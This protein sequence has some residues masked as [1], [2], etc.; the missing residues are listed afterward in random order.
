MH[1]SLR[2]VAALASVIAGLSLSARTETKNWTI[3]DGVLHDTKGEPVGM[4][5]V[6]LFQTHMVWASRKIDDAE[7]KKQI[8][9][10]AAENFNVIRM[11]LTW[12]YIEP[13]PDLFPDDPRYQDLMEE[14]GLFTGYVQ[15]LDTILDR[16]AE[17]GIKVIPE[18]HYA[19]ITSGGTWDK[20]K[21]DWGDDYGPIIAEHTPKALGWLANHWK[22]HPAIL[23]FEVPFNEPHDDPGEINPLF[24][25][26]TYYAFVQACARAIKTHAP[27]HLVF[28]AP[29]EWGSGSMRD[30]YTWR[31]PPEIDALFPHAYIGLH[32]PHP[33]PALEHA[34]SAGMA[35]YIAPFRASDRP[36]FVG[37]WGDCMVHELDPDTEKRSARSIDACLA[38]WF[39]MGLQG[40]TWWAW[41]NGVS[42]DLD[43]YR[44]AQKNV[45]PD[46]RAALRKWLWFQEAG[47][48]LS[49]A[50]VAVV[51]SKT[52]G[53]SE[54]DLE[55]KTGTHRL[56]W[57]LDIT[58]R[59]NSAYT[60]LNEH[61][62]ATPG[63]YTRRPWDFELKLAPAE[64]ART[65]R[66]A[67]TGTSSKH[68]DFKQGEE[69]S[70]LESPSG[71]A[72]DAKATTQGAR[73][74][75]TVDQAAGDPLDLKGTLDFLTDGEH[76]LIVQADDESELRLLSGR[77]HDATVSHDGFMK[78]L[79]G[80]TES[81]LELNVH[82][83]D[84]VTLEQLEA[85]PGVLSE[86]KAVLLDTRNLPHPPELSLPVFRFDASIDRAA[87]RKFLE[88]HG[89]QTR[90]PSPLLIA[91]NSVGVMVYNRGPDPVADSL[92]LSL[93]E[94]VRGLTRFHH[95]PEA[96]TEAVPSG[97]AL[98]V[99]L[100]P[101]QAEIFRYLR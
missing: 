21:I 64:K 70:F 50:Q 72:E 95:K 54:H 65:L 25:G 12:D 1:S 52:I 68:F 81:L 11:P 36:L 14:Y 84:V 47:P 61:H 20:K 19:S 67:V 63:L 27:H 41:N 17:H 90:A 71:P 53:A 3:R 49:T 7:L 59:D 42:S 2:T 37:E 34:Y 92:K 18:F 6:N 57:A 24:D 56:T 78:F 33:L 10:I 82:P 38:Q 31:I 100:E 79:Y 26:D 58:N 93:P 48:T 15:Q 97:E 40:A 101:F 88:R 23:G 43:S 73:V 39:A 16:C 75:A 28:M 13:A 86:Y 44:P 29:G 55:P 83:F 62:W 60:G 94:D 30:V 76:D 77:V 32:N 45:I 35:T 87:L 99:E 98:E 22:N 5:G 66:V 91:R 96:A 4:S 85:E 80:I 74:V 51:R 69:Y 89:I 46:A 8:D 9:A